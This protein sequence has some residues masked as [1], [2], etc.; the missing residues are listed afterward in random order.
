MCRL[1]FLPG[2]VACLLLWTTSVRAEAPPDPLRLVPEQAD[3]FIKVE[4][5]AQLL[6][7]VHYY[8]ILEQLQALSAVRER[9]D[10]TDTRRL[11]QLLA[12]FEKQLGRS[13]TELLDQL[14][15]GGAVLA[16][17]IG[18]NPA[19][20]LLI[21]QGK[22]EQLQ[23]KFFH[24]A[25]EIAEAEL[26]RQ[27]SKEPLK[28]HRHG[29]IEA[30]QIPGE[31]GP[32]FAALA[33]AALIVSNKEEVLKAAVAL[34]LGENQKSLAHVGRVAEARKLLPADPLAWAY[35]NFETT[36]HPVLG[37][38]DAA[39]GA[40]VLGGYID[41]ARRA[42]YLCA[43]FYATENGYLTTL[44][45]PKGRDGMPAE[46]AVH[47]APPGQA[48]SRPL[49]EPP[50]VLFSASS[51]LDAS[52][53]YDHRD[54]LLNDEQRRNL[55]EADKNFGKL[56]AGGQLNKMLVQAGPYLRLVA[57]HQDK[58]GYKTVPGVRL[59][60]FAAVL[61]LREPEAFGRSAE[62]I[63]R[64]LAL[65]GGAQVRLRLAEEKHG[66]LTLVG[67]RFAED[68]AVPGDVNNVR[69]NFSP[70]FVRVGN[71][72]VVSSTLEFGH[73]LIDVLQKEAAAP[74]PKPATATTQLQ[75]Y[76]S[77]GVALLKAFEDQLF[78]Q[79]VLAEAL[80]PEDARRQVQTL[81]DLV[82]RAGVVRLEF[83][84]EPQSFR[85]DIVHKPSGQKVP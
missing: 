62:A 54:R 9:F 29:G 67:Y 38:A 48:G 31:K 18:P 51:Y 26:A 15:G 65:I 78:A 47:M 12:Y 69:F 50:G 25:V 10:A 61:E 39:S 75:L 58:P 53:F 7:A 37:K 5:P 36:L 73:K 83:Q 14:A 55:Q 82:S 3:L 49:L 76:A 70:C 30:V 20:A 56:L 42:P 27:E 6:D 43:G 23:R 74:A 41:V 71:Q 13:R 4:K 32:T 60:A 11:L 46:M 52:Q 72:F 21:F 59:P 79:R 8:E 77:G 28:K 84:Y 17:K 68:F 80:T 45:M 64:T 2:C 33:G 1:R 24:L 44:R 57:A 85:L 19:P 81:L 16:V 63:L 34:H 35:L 22:D 66:A 40:A